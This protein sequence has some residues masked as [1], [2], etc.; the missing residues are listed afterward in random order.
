MNILIQIA[1]ILVGGLFIFS[2]LVKLN[3]PMGMAFKLHDYFAPDV[4]NLA[5]LNDYTLP[6]A[7][8]IILFE[9]ILGTALLIGYQVKWTLR[10]ILGLIIFFTFLTFYSAYYNKVTDCGCFGDAI[11]LTPWQ[12]FSKDVILLVLILFL[13]AGEKHLKPLLSPGLMK[14]K[15]VSATL[16]SAV[17]GWY[18][19]EHLPFIDFRP[20]AVG[21]SITEGMKSAEEMGL[22]PTQYGTIYTLENESGEKITVSSDDYIG[23]KWWEKPEWVI[24]ENLTKSVLIKEGY[25]PPVHDFSVIMNDIDVT[26]EVLNQEW[27]LLLPIRQLRKANEKGL[28]DLAEWTKKTEE[29]SIKMIG[30]TASGGDD[31]LEFINEGKTPFALANLDET[32]LKTMIRSNPGVIMLYKGT[33]VGK[34]HYNDLP[35][36]EELEALM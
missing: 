15:M 24:Q 10:A 29:L 3:D 17:L 27:I 25:E 6:L 5:F 2:G 20:Y 18:V 23:E 36:K 28:S 33:V 14:V 1:R 19:L 8:G 11:P 35:S 12:S 30:L 32:T 26:E 34:W 21:K 4:L 7:F 16:V 22:E 9:I 31:M 13:F